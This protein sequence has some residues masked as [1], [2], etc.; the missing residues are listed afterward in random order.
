NLI[1]AGRAE[2]DPLAGVYK[3]LWEDPGTYALNGERMAFYTQWVH[4]WADLKN[5]PLQGGDIW[6]LLYL[7]QRQVDKSDWDA[8]KAALGYGTYAQRPGNSGDASSTDGNVT[9]LLGLSWLAQRDQR[10]T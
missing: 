8:N 6:A 7:H 4:Y 3:R 5:D 9:L 1:V 10:P 2:A